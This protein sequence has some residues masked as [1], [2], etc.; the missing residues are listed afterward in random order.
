MIIFFKTVEI[1][2][3]PRAE[4]FGT[5]LSDFK[6]LEAGP[7]KK[8]RLDDIINSDY[9]AIHNDKQPSLPSGAS[10]VKPRQRKVRYLVLAPGGA[11]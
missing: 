5:S 8:K 4:I 7:P 9:K 6:Y 3:V 10:P 2:I 1:E 11:H